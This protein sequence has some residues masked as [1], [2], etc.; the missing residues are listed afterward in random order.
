MNKNVIVYE[1]VARELYVQGEE[2][3]VWVML[4]IVM[5]AQQRVN[6][7]CEVSPSTSSGAKPGHTKPV[8]G[9]KSVFKPNKPALE[10][11]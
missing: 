3:V 7:S 8:I 4:Q 5:L 2:V 10:N 11:F 9:T 6:Q 1:T